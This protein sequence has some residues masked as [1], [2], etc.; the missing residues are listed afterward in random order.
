V[1]IARQIGVG[2]VPKQSEGPKPFMRRNPATNKMEQVLDEGTPVY[3]VRIWDPVVKKQHEE[4]I[5]G[6]EAAQTRWRELQGSRVARPNKRLVPEQMTVSQAAA[7]F[8][9]AYKTDDAGGARPRATVKKVGYMLF[10]Y[11]VPEI[12]HVRIDYIDLPDLNDI[13]RNMVKLDGG[14]ASPG[15]KATLAGAIRSMWKWAREERLIAVNHALELK[16]GF[17]APARRRVVIPSLPLVERQAEVMEGCQ[18]GLG[19][20]VRLLA[21]TGMRWEEAVAVPLDLV[22]LVDQTI[23]VAWTA[24]EGGGKREVRGGAKTSAGQ[25]TIIIPDVAMPAVRRLVERA[26]EGQVRWP[27][28]Y[29]RLVN[30]VRGGYYPYISWRRYLNEAREQMGQE[31]YTPHELRHVCASF[32]I[33]TEGWTDVQIANQM[34]HASITTTKNIYGHLFVMDRARLLAA[35]NARVATLHIVADVA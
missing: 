23:V 21:Y 2:I 9:E 8:L 35:L 30:G 11:V 33:G 32:M 29:W 13:V 28:R 1:V 14:P 20:V 31:L 17:G 25:R 19:D 26:E 24:S 27:D 12:G 6:R 10:G 15:S 3:R 4:H 34:G 16:T 7:R 5:T 22:N 18:A